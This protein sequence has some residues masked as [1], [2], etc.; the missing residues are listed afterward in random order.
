[1]KIRQHGTSES[2]RF[3]A[4]IFFEAL[5]SYYDLSDSYALD[6]FARNG[7]L[8]VQCY[9]HKV[10]H[11]DAWELSEEHLVALEKLGAWDI[12]IG[13]SYA[14]A[15]TAQEQKYDMIVIDTPQGLHSKADGSR[16]C[17]HFDAIK[18]AAPLLKDEGLI[19]LYVNRKPYD[20]RIHGSYGYDE[21]EEY[22]YDQWMAI[23]R[24][25]YGSEIIDEGKALEAYKIAL[26]RL[27]FGV[28][29]CVIVPCFSDVDGLPPYA[30]RLGL[31]VYR[32]NTK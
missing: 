23:R 2:D 12:K 22:D 31:N 20:S 14:H 24:A 29:D 16:A 25:F 28:R 9:R 18:A 6:M 30:F 8:T 10:Q 26:G 3:S 5:A 27:G 17:E 19:V 7:E 11:F 21:Y 15:R 32:E 13:C 4:Q 1:M